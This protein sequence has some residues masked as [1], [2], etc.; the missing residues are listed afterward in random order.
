MG[1]GEG[2][3]KKKPVKPPRGL[4]RTNE[5][6]PDYEVESANRL[7][8]CAHGERVS[9]VTPALN[10]LLTEEGLLLY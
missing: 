4:T 6:H 1:I 8:P 10:L 9:A 7:E 2:K 5:L 3:N